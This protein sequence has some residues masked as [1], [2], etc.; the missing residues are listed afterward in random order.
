MPLSRD[1]EPEVEQLVDV[2]AGHILSSRFRFGDEDDLQRGLAEVFDALD[3]EREYR[4]DA[5]SR[6]DFLVK[7]ASGAR[8]GVEVKIAGNAGRVHAQCK[9]YLDSGL[10][11]GLL[12]VTTRRHHRKLKPEEFDKPFKVVWLGRSGL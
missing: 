2:L 7:A 5:R 4:I 6:I 8:I 12:L 11:D 3:F 10:I 1:F 9:R